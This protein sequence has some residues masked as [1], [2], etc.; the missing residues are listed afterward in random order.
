MRSRCELGV[1]CE[2]CGAAGIVGE[3]GE[4]TICLATVKA[5]SVRSTQDVLGGHVAGVAVA[6][7]G[8]GQLLSGVIGDLRAL[9]E[10]LGRVEAGAGVGY[11]GGLDP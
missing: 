5:L 8:S 1:V 6:Y 7:L 4:G 10:P 11:L 3:P 9:R 2:L